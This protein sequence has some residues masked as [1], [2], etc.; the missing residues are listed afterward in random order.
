MHGNE[1]VWLQCSLLNDL[2]VIHAAGKAT[3]RNGTL[4]DAVC[5]P[6]YLCGSV[7][8]VAKEEVN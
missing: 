5:I 1:G 6:I 8:A 3:V 7:S 2:S 4:F